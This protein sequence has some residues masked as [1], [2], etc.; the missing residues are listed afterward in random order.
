MRGIIIIAL[1]AISN[2]AWSQPKSVWPI[3]PDNAFA[4]FQ[5]N[6]VRV[7]TA[8]KEYD[9]MWLELCKAKKL[10][11]P[12]IE[13]FIR[14]FKADSKLELWARNT[15]KDTFTLLKEYN[16][17]VLSGKMGPKRR[18]GDLQVPEGFYFI[19]N[20]NNNSNYYLSLLV[21]YPNY[22]DLLKSDKEHPGSEIYIHGSCVTVGCMPMTD[23]YI[24]EIYTV[25]MQARTNGQL[26][27][28]VHIFPTKFTRHGL[29]Y[30]G[31]FYKENDN[32]RFWIN[33]KKGYD[34]FEA[35]KKIFPVMYD[36]QGNYVY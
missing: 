32:Q 3:Y 13:V 7:Q 1:I 5:K 33:L 6:S 11:Y 35:N 15:N 28:P 23:D 12:N 36:E 2:F 24:K 4:Q 16:V 8:F 27:I 18:E 31:R 26:Y 17:C 34:Y 29:D 20:F 19:D 14:E 25:T 9:N 30:L 21:S 22:S 10:N